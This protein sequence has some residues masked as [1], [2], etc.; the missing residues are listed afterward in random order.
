[1]F[2]GQWF[3]DEISQYYLRARMYD[4]ALMRFTS[5][6]PVRG[7]FK[8]PLTLHVY[9]YCLNDPINRTDPEGKVAWNIVGGVVTGYALHFHAIRLATYASYGKWKFFDL[10]EAT[11]QFNVVAPFIAALDVLRPITQIALIIAENASESCMDDVTGLTTF[12]SLAIDPVVYALYY[13]YMRRKERRLGIGASDIQEF[14]EW[15]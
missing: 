11:A 2:T 3:D 10:A 7:K 8:N 13:D 1:M 12:E 15:R 4:P 9:L 6:D 5:R 14:M